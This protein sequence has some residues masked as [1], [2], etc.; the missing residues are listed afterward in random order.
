[1]RMQTAT[2]RD[3]DNDNHDD[4]NDVDDAGYDED[5]GDADADD[6]GDDYMNTADRTGIAVD[7]LRLWYEYLSRH[8]DLSGNPHSMLVIYF[9]NL[10]QQRSAPLA[11]AVTCSE[12]NLTYA[13]Y[14]H[15]LHCT[16]LHYHYIQHSAPAHLA[17]NSNSHFRR[18]FQ[19]HSILNCWS[20]RCSGISNTCH[21]FYLA[22]QC[23]QFDLVSRLATTTSVWRIPGVPAA[24]RD[25]NGESP[26]PALAL[27][28]RGLRLKL[29]P[30]GGASSG[31]SQPE[32]LC[33][34]NTMCSGPPRRHWL[35]AWG[36]QR[37]PPP[38]IGLF[39]PCFRPEM[40]QIA[41][42]IAV[43]IPDQCAVIIT[44]REREKNSR[45]FITV[46]QRVN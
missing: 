39:T 18:R 17:Q 23:A 21:R 24:G 8:L 25:W 34:T 5:D 29:S 43:Q 3:N 19:L 38:A 20:N 7:R 13:Y 1:M 26:I 32:P 10:C 11:F 33:T 41:W 31:W 36:P 42:S 14:L 15:Y 28:P 22:V 2:R 45:Q 27:A 12:L 35:H 30:A 37:R 9:A 6:D 40:P 46:Y 44:A 16:K 4:D